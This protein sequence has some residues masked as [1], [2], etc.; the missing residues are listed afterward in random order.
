M[1]FT[2]PGYAALLAATV[3]GC[4]MLRGRARLLLLL[5][6]S[7]SFYFTWG[8]GYV[9]VLALVTVVH[10]AAAL[11]VERSDHPRTRRLWLGLAVAASLGVLAVFKAA[12]AQGAPFGPLLDRA[13]GLAG[14][15]VLPA[16]LSF[17]TLQALG[18][19]LDVYD[20]RVR[21]TRDLP[22]F[23]AFLS[24]FPQLLAGPIERAKDLLPQ[25]AAPRV[26]GADRLGE[27]VAL[28]LVG[29]TK[30]LVL[31]DRLAPLL[32]PVFRDP[33][34]HDGARL[35]SSLIA[36]P[37][38][39][40]LDFSG[41]TDIARGSARM[42]GI[43]LT[44]NFDFP[45]AAT[46]PSEY[47]RRWHWTLTR[48]V[49]DHVFRRLGGVRRRRRGRTAANL[50]ISLGLVGLWHGPSWTFLLWGVANG[51][52]LAVQFAFRT[53]RSRR[54]ERVRRG[55]SKPWLA[56][57]GGWLATGAVLFG[58]APLF[59]CPDLGTAIG[60]WRGLV[61]EPWVFG[62]RSLDAALAVFLCG[63]FLFQA[64]GRAGWLDV[65]RARAPSPLRALAAAL[66]LYAL[67]FGA[68]PSGERFVYTRL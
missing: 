33:A 67:L 59:F 44:K 23:A 57:L 54:P 66:L 43:E 52:V 36:M 41:Y 32:A 30:K 64:A 3:L 7:Y 5:A 4:L 29:L 12:S 50:V 53:R 16:G 48:W 65:I 38:A 20:R 6:A 56:A 9:V 37:V 45:F 14:A 8:A 61:L 31:A 39:L 34:A 1:S 18:Y 25:L 62:P 28:V 47:W 42:L 15:V 58:L 35:L 10:F 60:Y 68:V 40:Y 21:A 2:S 51:L 27:G 46:R 55:R 63:F 49:M 22:S 17:Y 11:G 24:F 26:P 13:A 19:T